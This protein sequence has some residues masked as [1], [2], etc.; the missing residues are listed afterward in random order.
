MGQDDESNRRDQGDSSVPPEGLRSRDV[1]EVTHSL[2]ELE[3]AVST[4]PPTLDQPSIPPVLAASPADR[5]QPFVPA[6]PP[7][8]PVPHAAGFS[9][10]EAP[11][12]ETAVRPDHE[13]DGI[14]VEHP[15]RYLITRALRSGEVGQ[16]NVAFDRH[17][18]REVELHVLEVGI[19]V[20]SSPAASAATA[21]PLAAAE[22]R[23]VTEARV[24]GRLDHPGIVPVHELGRRADGS[25]FVTSRLVRGQTFDQAVGGERL[26][27]R[28]A[29]LPQ[30][31]AA[32]ETLGFAHA[33][34]VVHRLLTPSHV[35]VGAWGETLVLGWGM[36]KVRD[37][38][39][40]H[41][42][43]LRD[44]LAAIQGGDG[45]HEHETLA[46][47]SP[48]H[49]GAD[50]SVLDARSD[51]YCLGA[52]LYLLLTG[53]PPHAAETSSEL[54]AR[55]LGHRVDSAL[56][57]EPTCPVALARVAQRALAKNPAR[58]YPDAREFAAALRSWFSE[59]VAMPEA[60]GPD[61]FTRRRLAL[62]LVV[63]AVGLIACWFG[64]R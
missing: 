26:A 63:L 11:T 22:T 62:L 13:G 25:L 8:A 16:G 56:V 2:V 15:G 6:K 36:A 34:G 52:L 17:M 30:L 4:L 9:I 31:L 46:Y 14:T 28:L 37:Q 1:A 12:L 18:Q 53:R 10:S 20:R 42:S 41:A 61:T 57:H 64:F 32:A 21:A 5:S 40:V 43:A 59:R 49:L 23:F 24:S 44:E 35:V 19:E 39:D 3:D 50:L 48:E 7:T 51:V 60:R 55:V 33:H 54:V 47:L 58:R 45:G 29:L 27:G 38:A